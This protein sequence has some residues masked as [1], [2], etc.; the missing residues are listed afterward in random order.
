[1]MDRT[2][3]LTVCGT[4]Q[5]SP[6][7]WNQDGCH[8]FDVQVCEDVPTFDEGI[9]RRAL[10]RSSLACEDVAGLS[11]TINRELWGIGYVALVLSDAANHLVV[12]EV[13]MS[14]G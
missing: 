12:V 11:R 2:D 14:R 13:S 1:M 3:A 4:R 6:V 5:L 9:I 10:L 8:G 7:P